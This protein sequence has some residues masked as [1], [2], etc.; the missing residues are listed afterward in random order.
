MTP[1]NSAKEI[2]LS[3]CVVPGRILM[4]YVKYISITIPGKTHHFMIL[5]PIPE[6]PIILAGKI[7]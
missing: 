4:L 3:A 6:W 7:F 1:R 2:M 5:I